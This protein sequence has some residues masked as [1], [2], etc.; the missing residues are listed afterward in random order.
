MSH[1]VQ[2]KRHANSRDNHL[3][4]QFHVSKDPFVSYRW[5][6][7]ISL[8]QGMQPIQERL[9]ITVTETPSEQTN[10]KKILH[11][12]LHGKLQQRKV[13]CSPTW[14][15]GEMQ[16]PELFFPKH[17]DRNTAKPRK[18]LSRCPVA[19]RNTQR[20]GKKVNIIFFTNTTASKRNSY[21]YT[22]RMY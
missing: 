5:D 4:Q 8:K 20:D 6:P 15:Y 22:P 17:T 14:T 10:H 11:N 18:S 1:L 3:P 16:F 9:Q 19:E 12:K 2:F 13:F 21:F 7:E